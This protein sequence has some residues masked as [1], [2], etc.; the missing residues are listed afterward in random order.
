MGEKKYHFGYSYLAAAHHPA[1]NEIYFKKN[2]VYLLVCFWHLPPALIAGVQ[3]F[4]W[5]EQ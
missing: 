5:S 2:M 1:L 3:H 4:G